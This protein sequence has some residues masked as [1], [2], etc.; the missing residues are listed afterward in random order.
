MK[1]RIGKKKLIWRG[2]GDNIDSGGALKI[3]IE[4]RILRELENN[5]SLR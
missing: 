2:V 1:N 4:C 5:S 3:E